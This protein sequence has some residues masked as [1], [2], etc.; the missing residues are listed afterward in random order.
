MEKVPT[1]SS[2]DDDEARHATAWVRRGARATF[3]A[4]ASVVRGVNVTACMV[5][6]VSG[7]VI[8]GGRARGSGSEPLSVSSQQH[9][10]GH[11][12]KLRPK[13]FSSG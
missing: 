1:T 7:G 3:G 4:H 8:E 2:L 10:F 9:P 13:T 11:G 5:T 12:K 6:T